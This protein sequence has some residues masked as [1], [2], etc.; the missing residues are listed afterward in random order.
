[1]N[2]LGPLGLGLLAALIAGVVV[3]TCI[4]PA[5]LRRYVQSRKP[6]VASLK[7]HAGLPPS[8][9]EQTANKWILKLNGILC[10]CLALL[11]L[12]NIFSGPA[13]VGRLNLELAGAAVF[14]AA[15]VLSW[16][17]AAGSGGRMAMAKEL[18]TRHLLL[19]AFAVGFIFADISTSPH[20]DR[21]SGFRDVF[22]RLHW[23][24]Q[25]GSGETADWGEPLFYLCLFG[26]PTGL[27]FAFVTLLGLKLFEK[28]F[29]SARK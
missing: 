15:S 9:R 14:Y 28:Y 5:R 10:L 7:A 24:W 13:S 12:L 23:M 17:L 6:E 29:R 1:M 21:L 27:L 4:L 19:A 2:D 16:F 26:V 20:N 11:F 3:A 22:H 8:G 25:G 18:L